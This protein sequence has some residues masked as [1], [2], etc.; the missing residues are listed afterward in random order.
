MKL[1][2]TLLIALICMFTTVCLAAP[3]AEGEIAIF[4][5]ISRDDGRGA[6]LEVDTGDVMLMATNG[7]PLERLSHTV[8]SYFTNAS[9]EE[10]TAFYWQRLNAA[11]IGENLQHPASMSPGNS[12]KVDGQL[13][14]YEPVKDIYQGEHK[15]QSAAWIK[16][17]LA[18][19]RKPSPITG[20]WLRETMFIWNAKMTDGKYAVFVIALTDLSFDQYYQRYQTRTL[21]NIATNIF[22]PEDEE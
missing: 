10:V 21:I 14:G 19:N 3:A 12:S 8:K 6:M 17:T 4:P 7:V 15:V 16:N 18:I 2:I 1:R 5:G 13:R 22:V 11:E 9:I 20:Q